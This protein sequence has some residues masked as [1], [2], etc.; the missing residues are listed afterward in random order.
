MKILI[1]RI[2]TCNKYTIGHLYIDNMYFCDTLEDTD[3]GL[4]QNMSLNLLKNTKIKHKTAIPTGEYV[5]RTDIISP[6][7]SKNSYY[8]KVCRGYVPRIMDVPGFDGV[9]IHCGNDEND[10]SGCILLGEN[11]LKGK[12]INSRKNFEK[13]YKKIKNN[14]FISIK[15]ISKY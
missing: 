14:N 10:T 15:I 11:K 7:F 8:M 4:N 3:R 13:F 2:F 1:E 5:L 12:V 6:R 9:L